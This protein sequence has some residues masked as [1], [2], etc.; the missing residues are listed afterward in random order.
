MITMLSF[1]EPA[2]SLGGSAGFGRCRHPLQH[3]QHQPTPAVGLQSRPF[4]FPQQIQQ[5]SLRQPRAPIRQR[6]HPLQSRGS[7]GALLGT[8]PCPSDFSWHRAS[9]KRRHNL[10]TSWRLHHIKTSPALYWSAQSYH[11]G[12]Q[13]GRC[14]PQQQAVEFQH[15]LVRG[16]DHVLVL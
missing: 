5:P 3:Q 14:Y 4:P 1:A 10:F 13:Q 12:T 8:R 15:G 7:S 16:R 11:P 9:A 6:T 2:S